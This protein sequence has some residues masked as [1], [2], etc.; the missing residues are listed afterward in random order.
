[1]YSEKAGR[2]RW[3]GCTA[4]A[5]CPCEGPGGCWW[6]NRKHTV[7][8]ECRRLD[9]AM[10]SISGRRAVALIA[11]EHWEDLDLA[12]HEPE[13]YDETRGKSDGPIW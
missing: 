11:Q 6:V 10:K 2:C 12:I 9:D 4:A 3:C 13:A 1:M 7:C 5:P 8:S